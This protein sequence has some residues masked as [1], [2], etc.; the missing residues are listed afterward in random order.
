MLMPNKKNSI[1]F[2]IISCVMS[3][4]YGILNVRGAE[5]NGNVSVVDKGYSEIVDP[6][7]P[8]KPITENPI[9][10][11]NESLRIDYVTSFDFGKVKI[12]DKDRKFNLLAK[13]IHQKDLPEEKLF[14][15]NFIQISDFRPESTGWTLQLKQEAQFQTEDY[16]ELSGAVVSM[17]KGWANS[18]VTEGPPT[19]T[20]DTINI[21]NIGEVYDVARAE[22][23][24][25]TGVWMISHGASEKNESNQEN[26][27][28]KDDMGV[29]R[30]SA[31]SLT[32][33]K[34]VK[35]ASKP[36]QT[37]FTWILGSTP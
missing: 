6:E 22:K 2:A 34:N 3:F 18:V 1:F 28:S 19:V 32:I 31:V 12:S 29:M 4:N 14:R 37:K 36:Y 9:S 7:N 27:I 25:G 20:R 11:K 8:S 35:V 17:D 23:D 13:E 5:S 16:D 24:S 15:G 30:N 21:N 10:E 33:P 26:T